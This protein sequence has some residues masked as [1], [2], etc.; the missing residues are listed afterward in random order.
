MSL[1]TSDSPSLALI[2]FS[3]ANPFADQIRCPTRIF[4]FFE[5]V[6][7]NLNVNIF[8]LI[9]NCSDWFFSRSGAP[10]KEEQNS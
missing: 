10:K 7:S 1:E 2:P 6:L 5:H 9:S 4:T 8:L 3:Y